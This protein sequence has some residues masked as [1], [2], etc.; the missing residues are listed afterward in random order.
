MKIR[1]ARIPWTYGELF[2]AAILVGVWIAFIVKIV[3]CQ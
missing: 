1:Q 2:E 3:G